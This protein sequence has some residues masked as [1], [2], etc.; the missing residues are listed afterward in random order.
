MRR[1]GTWSGDSGGSPEDTT[2]CLAEVSVSGPG[3]FIFQQCSRKRRDGLGGLCAQHARKRADGRP[4][5]IPPEE[6]A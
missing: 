3:G 5:H 6:P 4:V 2:K 1:Y